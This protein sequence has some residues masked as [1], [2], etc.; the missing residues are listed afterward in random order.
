MHEG[1]PALQRVP[2][3]AAGGSVHQQAV[4]QHVGRDDLVG[5]T[6]VAHGQQVAQR[7][8][9]PDVEPGVVYEVVLVRVVAARLQ[10]LDRGARIERGVGAALLPASEVAVGAH[11]EALQEGNLVV[12]DPAVEARAAVGADVG[13]GEPAG[14]GL[15]AAEL[16]GEGAQR[17]L[18]ALRVE[19]V[20][21]DQGPG[22]RLFALVHDDLLRGGRSRQGPEDQQQGDAQK[23]VHGAGALPAQ[24]GLGSR[25]RRPSKV[26]TI[27]SSPS[28]PRKNGCCNGTLPY[29]VSSTY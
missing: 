11:E 3:L 1:E 22:A 23:L 19:G 10:G 18:H 13:R 7:R 27:T 25:Q 8:I 16:A 20:G 9:R 15:D 12:P 17:Q 14:L 6:R 29:G 24:R 21:Q 28:R 4:A 2:A 26:S 5:R